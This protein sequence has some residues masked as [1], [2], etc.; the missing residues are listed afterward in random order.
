MCPSIKIFQD[1]KRDSRPLALVTAYDATLAHLAQE[2]GVDALLVGDSLGMVIQG[3]ENTLGVTLDEMVYHSRLVVYGAPDLF[4]IADMPFMSYQAAVEDA[5]RS[6]G[7]LLKDGQV[8]AVK[9]EGGREIIAQVKALVANG[10]PVMGHVGLKPQSIHLYGGYSKRGKEPQERKE[11]IEG[12][13]ALEAAGCFAVVLESIPYDLAQ[14]LTGSLTIPTI[15]IGAGPSCDG[16]IQVF[17]DLFGLQPD[18][19]PKHTKRYSPIGDM[20]ITGLKDYVRD[21]HQREFKPG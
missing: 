17:H 15:G 6:A 19:K 12:A 13:H 16:Q 11:I 2:A 20:I 5:L 3:R 10:I 18:F 1:A 8:R 9:L 14:E 7:R 4:I 21:V